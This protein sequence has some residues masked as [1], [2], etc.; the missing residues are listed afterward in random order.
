[1]EKWRKQSL[2]ETEGVGI[3]MVPVTCKAMG[4]N[5]NS[6]P[7]I[8]FWGKPKLCTGILYSSPN[9]TNSQRKPQMLYQVYWDFFLLASLPLL[10]PN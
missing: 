8:L 10:G 7:N 9:Q 2:E 3:P 4:L 5:R 6:L 1:M